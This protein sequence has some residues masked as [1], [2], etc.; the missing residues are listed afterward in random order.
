MGGMA[1]VTMDAIRRIQA[2]PYME[3]AEAIGTTSWYKTRY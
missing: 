1:H 2:E 3:A